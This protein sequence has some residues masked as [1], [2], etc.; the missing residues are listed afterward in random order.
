MAV[1]EGAATPSPSRPRGSTGPQGRHRP[2]FSG[3]PAASSSAS[4]TRWGG[5]LV[6]EPTWHV[7]PLVLEDCDEPGRVH[8]PGLARDVR[9]HHARRVP[10]DLSA[11]RSADRWREIGPG[12]P[13]GWHQA[14]TLVA[15]DGTGHMVGFASAGPSR[16]EDAPT[17]WE[18]YVI[19]L[20]PEAHG[21]GLADALVRRVLGDR[22]A[23]LWVAEGN[24]R[25][26]AF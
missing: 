4:R 20:L 22:P 18:L 17:E 23:S 10:R 19:N 24:A 1:V 6:A 25:A 11:E 15:R 14:T 13:R 12:S 2:G 5:R 26:R 21:A 8:M 9:R 7:S 3:E 16:D